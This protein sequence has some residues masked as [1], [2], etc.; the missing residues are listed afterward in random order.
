MRVSI[1]IDLGGTNMRAGLVGADGSVLSVVR[2]G[3]PV[4]EGPEAAVQG[5]AAMVREIEQSSPDYKIMGIGIGSPGPLNRH[6]KRLLNPANL[7]G[8]E[9]FPIGKRLEE[10][11]HYHVELDNDAKC[12]AF[13]E[14]MFGAGR[15]LQNFIVMTFGTGIG[16]GI[17]IEGRMLYGKSD[18]ACEV[19]HMTLYPEGEPCPCGN[20]G[21]FERYASASA[22]RRRGEAAFGASVG[23]K[24][25]FRR[26]GEGDATAIR[27]LREVSRDI[28]IGTASLVNLFDPEAIILAGGAFTDGG[29]PLPHWIH[30]E[31]RG[32]CFESSWSTLKMIPSALG[33]NAGILGAA[34]LVFKVLN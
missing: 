22:I 18:S 32:R 5:M 16:S 8:F 33:G 15:G 14:S 3:T 24:E 10:L 7:K 4:S 30:E 34:S 13:G 9:N 26:M 12:A 31:M 2:K 21:C 11:T 1:G 17:F 29:G 20:R 28:A 19:G 27:V 23:T 25:I 6:E